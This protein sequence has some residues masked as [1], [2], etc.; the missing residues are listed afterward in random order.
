MI[1]NLRFGFATNSSSNHS[2][3]YSTSD[4]SG[5]G[6]YNDPGRYGWNFFGLHTPVEKADYMR[7][8]LLRWLDREDIPY[9]QALDL[10]EDA[11]PYATEM[12]LESYREVYS[13]GDDGGW[14]DGPT[15]DHQS[16]FSIPSNIVNPDSWEA[17]R[18]LLDW[19]K[20]E[21]LENPDIHIFGGNDNDGDYVG[22]YI[23]EPYT[24]YHF[25]WGNSNSV[26]CLFFKE[27]ASGSL[28]FF[29]SA[30]GR[31]ARTKTRDGQDPLFSLTPDLADLT[32]TNFCR[33]G[34][35]FCYRDC[36]PEGQH[37]NLDR[38]KEFLDQ[39]KEASVFEIAIGGGEPLEH[40]QFVQILREAKTR[41]VIPNFSTASKEKLF[42][43]PELQ[44]IK[45]L[46]GAIA[47][48]T[49]SLEEA[50]HWEKTAKELK[51]PNPTIHYILGSQSI[52]EFRAFLTGFFA[53]VGWTTLIL[54]KWKETG[55]AGPAPHSIEG[56][57]EAI[58]D[59]VSFHKFS[60]PD[61]PR[62][63]WDY[64]DSDEERRSRLPNGNRIGIDSFLAAEMAEEMPEVDS[65]LY[66][67][68]D[69]RFSVY[70]DAVSG[71]Y[72]P[73]SVGADMISADDLRGAWAQILEA[74]GFQV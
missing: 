74:Q 63:D 26:D 37:A 45:R 55:R 46:C 15:I 67:S 13:D 48:S 31:R 66:G 11:F 53:E 61:R 14:Y 39:C 7:T 65:I 20:R 23:S 41:G 42:A 68:D 73:H 51:L 36:T 40:P 19:M 22:E 34:C 10:V 21:I 3:V 2:I 49:N 17:M 62:W 58:R 70:Y 52:D 12:D 57:G 56:W 64:F 6:E 18:P 24:L 1:S 72:G 4:L 16:S 27:N 59:A 8:A 35:S 25:P 32:I 29:N 30:N 43:H 44:A 60:E 9:N 38:I 28:T 71:L 47:F 33:K 5:Y 50:L 54:L 69:G